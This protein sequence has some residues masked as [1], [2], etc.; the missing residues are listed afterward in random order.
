[1]KNFSDARIV[2]GSCGLLLLSFGALVL[3]SGLVP[4]LVLLVPIYGATYVFSIVN[5]AQLTKAV[6]TE[7][8]GSMLAVD[9]ALGSVTRMVSPLLGTTVL[10][11]HGVSGIGLSSSTAVAL[12]LIFTQVGAAT[13]SSG[14]LRKD[15]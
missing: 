5:T 14:G 12:A 3:Q 15:S 9:M 4:Y 1:M 6:T 10:Q 8:L 7:Q 13:G 2:L 11:R